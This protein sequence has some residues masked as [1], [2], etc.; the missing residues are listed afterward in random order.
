[1]KTRKYT[2]PAYR[3]NFASRYSTHSTILRTVGE[4]KR[5]LDV[6]CYSGYLGVHDANRNEWYG[7]DI[8]KDALEKARN[9]YKDVRF[10]DLNR[11]EK[12][13]WDVRFDVIVFADVLEHVIFPEE[14][15]SFFVKT[16]LKETGM[17]ILS[18]P[19]IANWRIRLKLLFGLFDYTETGILDR[20]HL[21]FYT[22]KT[23]IR[24]IS[25][26]D[27]RIEKAMA[28]ATFL[29]YVIDG[30]RGFFR[31][32]LATDIILICKKD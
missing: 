8:S 25:Q 24:L 7:I 13:P 14:V 23:A 29:G 1:M 4:R 15:L 22:Y 20:T 28:G 31:N 9:T 18:L 32:L 26:A 16:Y 19:N 27:L 30:T 12:L 10:Y 2:I 21:H 3:E 6:G 5:I 17:V 11:L